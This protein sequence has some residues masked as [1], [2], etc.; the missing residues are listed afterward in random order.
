MS[1]IAISRQLA[2]I[3]GVTGGMNQLDRELRHWE[4]ITTP[5]AHVHTSPWATL[6]SSVL[7]NDYRRGHNR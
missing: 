6:S 1:A 5:S 3:T 2:T 7:D 4:M